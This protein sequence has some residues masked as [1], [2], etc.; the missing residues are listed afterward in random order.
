TWIRLD[1]KALT[2]RELRQIA[3]KPYRFERKIVKKRLR[4]ASL[5][6]LKPDIKG[7]VVMA[8]V[9]PG[10]EWIV[11]LTLEWT[12]L[13]APALP[14]G[15]ACLRLWRA[16]APVMKQFGCRATM[17]LPTEFTPTEF[18]LQPDEVEH[19]L[20]VFVNGTEGPIHDDELTGSIQVFRIDLSATSP[21]FSSL[22][23]LS[24][25]RPSTGIVVHGPTVLAIS[26]NAETG[27]GEDVVWNWRN[28]QW[29]L[30]PSGD[31]LWSVAASKDRIIFWNEAQLSVDV[32]ELS[33][34]GK[35]GLARRHE[36]VANL[37]PHTSQ[38]M[39]PITPTLL[40]PWNLADRHTFLVHTE[41]AT[42]RTDFPDAEADHFK[43]S[44]YPKDNSYMQ[45]PNDP[46]S[47]LG[48]YV[49]VPAYFVKTV[50]GHLVDLSPSGRLTVYYAMTG[51]DQLLAGASNTYHAFANFEDRA[52]GKHHPFI[53]PFSG[54]V[55]T[56]T[57]QCD[58]YIWRMK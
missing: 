6:R 1:F 48:T 25:P 15:L 58:F 57:Q 50:S 3:T 22:A 12:S 52:S 18:C 27:Q 9:V 7:F 31:T 24:T 19:C 20:L 5:T 46:S 54:V 28:G 29:V 35:W 37:A 51:D 16:A 44:K 40:K 13:I 17:T 8:D 56:V 14:S 49:E 47:P 34:E 53:C 55:G 41:N 23:S 10:G 30:I 32:H 42:I 4:D 39:S 26:F 36:P 11:T 43:F 33:T 2:I 21:Q 45:D 38:I